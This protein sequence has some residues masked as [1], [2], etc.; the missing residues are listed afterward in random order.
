[1]DTPFVYNR[2]VS[3]RNFI[4]RKTEVP[5]LANLLREG[6]NVVMYE[7]P[8]SGKDSLLQQVF[9]DM[10]LSGMQFNI[11]GLTLLGVRSVEAFCI[12][13]GTAM[14]RLYGASADEYRVL[15]AETLGKTHFVFDQQVYETTGNIISLG[16][17]IDDDDIRALVALPYR[18]ARR[19]GRKLYVC[20]D[21]FQNIMQT[22]DGDRICAL[23][24]E[25]FKARTQDDRAC[26]TYIM[27]GSRV[28]A[29]KEIFGHRKL[30]FRQVERVEFSGVD[31]KDIV[32]SV[33]R[34][35]LSSGKVID[36][37]LLLGACNLLGCNIYYI[38]CFAS[39]CDSLSKGYIMEP[40][41]MEALSDLLA[42]HEPGFR[43]IM[44]DL[45][46]FQVNLLRA[47]VD[48]HT[49]FSSAE[50]IRHYNLNSSA[51]VRRLKDALCKKEII[52]FD[53]EDVPRIIDP[54]FEYWVT[55]TFF[56]K[57]PE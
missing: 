24:Q 51:N 28:N 19:S 38:N 12:S 16:W 52:T 27:Y 42:I 22:E 46:T 23:M 14:L 55:R 39:I 49:K 30:F 56:G 41:L 11:A 29:M 7:P 31:A 3:G 21:E 20:I 34:G 35:F 45:T 1:M 57:K 10:K 6:E 18:L 36:R 37:E 2:P 13:L 44:S 50:V 48:G 15:V 47:V 32:D 17:D 8:K 9:Y 25:V 4:G 26:A 40:V 53:D 5:V 33:N 54:L 43:A